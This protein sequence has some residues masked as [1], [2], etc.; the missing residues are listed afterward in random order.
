MNF[1]NFFLDRL[2][3]PRRAG[4][5]LALIVYAFLFAAVAPA[6]ACDPAFAFR[7]AGY[8]CG[9]PVANFNAFAYGGIPTNA[10]FIDPR[11]NFNAGYGNAFAFRANFGY[12]VPAFRQRALFVPRVQPFVVGGGASAAASSGFGGAAAASAGGGFFG[13]AASA[14]A[15]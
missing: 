10:A 5:M 15:R 3:A 13:G 14:V 8:G 11:F 9:A 6:K 4:L 2:M 12:G 1:V 7:S